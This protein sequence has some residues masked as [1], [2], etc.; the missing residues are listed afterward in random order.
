MDFPR[1]YF[2]SN[3]LLFL[4]YSLIFVYSQAFELDKI[5]V[6][7]KRDMTSEEIITGVDALEGFDEKPQGKV[8][9]EL[10]S[11]P[12]VSITQSGAPGQQSAI[13]IRGSEARH[14]LVIVDGV[15][16]N[17]PSNTE[18]FFNASLLNLS[19]V[20]KIEVLKGS[21]TLLYGSEAIG[22][23]INIVT[24]KGAGRNWVS[25]S[26]GFCQ[27]LSIDHT[28]FL[29]NGALPHQRIYGKK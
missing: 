6:G 8:L 10:T 3:I 4:F 14:V 23:V 11:L 18:K 26:S 9:D 1:R 16:M 12:G 20:E 21:Q 5:V 22:G 25:A 19:D 15:R 27:G 29:E 2:G 13:F 24:K 28:V 17:D 7:S